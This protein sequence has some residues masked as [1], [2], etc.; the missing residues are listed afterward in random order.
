[1]I[2]R[3]D[4]IYVVIIGTL[5]FIQNKKQKMLSFFPDFLETLFGWMQARTGSNKMRED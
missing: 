5:G 1:M 2:D 4:R 3:H